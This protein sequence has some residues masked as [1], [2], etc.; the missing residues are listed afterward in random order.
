MLAKIEAEAQ[1]SYL[2]VQVNDIENVVKPHNLAIR[3]FF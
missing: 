3:Y 2:P 1:E